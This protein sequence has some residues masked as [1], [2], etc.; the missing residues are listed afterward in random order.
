MNRLVK[1][2]FLCVLFV[3]AKAQN[4][5][6]AQLLNEM[7]K[8]GVY[9]SVLYIAAHP[10][11]ENTRMLSYLVN[12]KKYRTGYLSLTRGDGGQNLIGEEQGVM[13]GMIRTQELIAARKVDGAEQF[14]TRAYDFGFSKSPDEALSIWGHDAILADVVWAI[15]TFQPDVIICRFPTTGEGGHGHHTA[16]AL[17]ASE[18]FDAAADPTKFPEQLKAGAS[19][20][21]AKRLMWNTFSFDNM[22]TTDESQFKID[23]GGY[24]ALLGLSYGELSATSRSRH[25]SQGFG[26]PAQRGTSYEYLKTIKGSAP[27]KDLMDGIDTS[28]YKLN[29]KDGA[30]SK[31]AVRFQHLYQQLIAQYEPMHPEKSIPVLQEMESLL[32]KAQASTLVQ[33]KKGLIQKLI[34]HAAGIYFEAVADQQRQIAGDSIRLTYS[35]VYRNPAQVKNVAA[36]F[37]GWKNENM[38]IIWEKVDHNRSMV[39]KQSVHIPMQGAL[40]QPYWLS[41]GLP[42]GIFN[43]PDQKNRNL[44]EIAGPLVA[45]EMDIND[46]RYTYQVPVQYKFTD[47]TKGEIYQPIHIT[48]PILMDLTPNRILANQPKP[49]QLEVTF[50]ENFS[51]QMMVTLHQGKQQLVVKDTVIKMEKNGTWK[52]QIDLPQGWLKSGSIYVTLTS[53]TWKSKGGDGVISKK[54]Y[55]IEYGY[56]PHIAFHLADSVQVLNMDLK[57]AGKKI[58]FI[59]GAGD[60]TVEVLKD[61]GYEVVILD[62]QMIKAKQHEGLDAIVTGVRA[63]NVQTW[64]DEVYPELIQY[65]E[66]GGVLLVQY[67]TNNRLAPMNQRMSPYPFTITRNRITDEKA[68]VKFSNPQHRVFNYPNKITEAD[69]EGWV[70]ERSIYHAG[71]VDTKYEDLLEMNDPGEKALPGA[72]I[73]AEHGKGRFVYTGLSLFRQLPAGVTGAYRLLVNLLSK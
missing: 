14:F 66:N 26:V 21:K 49:L 20:W 19:V 29:W 2:L 42:N 55:T 16:S 45:F 7:Q 23:C 30:K 46:K 38:S 64:L 32:D 67:N 39:A 13:M 56:I 34:Q 61:L 25:S 9:P 17:L 63:Y 15:R 31:D 41:E 62:Q 70:Q 18:A 1:S 10:D 48:N 57:T 53:P 65:V 35:F 3:T 54:L 28:V 37:V 44:P 73:V 4:Y 36:R 33:Y 60:V 51:D 8:V 72:L 40:T 52:S 5:N 47:P 58:G 11:D 12:E 22:N 27:V 43:V 24:N 68:K 71:S 6:A 69:F 59:P 50:L